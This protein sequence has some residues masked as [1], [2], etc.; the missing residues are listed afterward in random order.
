MPLVPGMCSSCK[1]SF[2]DLEQ[3]QNLGLFQGL[4]SSEKGKTWAADVFCDEDPYFRKPQQ[5]ELFSVYVLGV[6]K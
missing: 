2:V 1:E 4:K 3:Q 5:I 6:K